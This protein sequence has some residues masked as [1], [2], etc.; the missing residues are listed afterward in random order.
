MIRSALLGVFVGA[1]GL[2]LLI[3][4]LGSIVEN[5]SLLLWIIGVPVGLFVLMVLYFMAA[6]MSA[7]APDRTQALP[8]ASLKPPQPA[9]QRE[10]LP[11]TTVPGDGADSPGHGNLVS[12]P[13]LRRLPARWRYRSPPMR[14]P[15]D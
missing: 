14:P 3:I 6:R 10:V 5:P 9:P 7:S 11:P 2:L 12:F 15:A 1:P 4:L 13:A 8:P